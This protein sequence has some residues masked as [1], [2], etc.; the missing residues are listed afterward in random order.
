MGQLRIAIKST[1][2]LASSVNE[3]KRKEEEATGLFEAFARTAK[4]PPSFIT[5]ARRLIRTLEVSEL[6][7]VSKPKDP[8]RTH[9]T[10][11][12]R[13]HLCSDI[14]MI[15]KRVSKL[16]TAPFAFSAAETQEALIHPTTV[17]AS[18]DAP[19]SSKNAASLAHL[20]PED[21]V[22]ELELEL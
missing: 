21:G 3:T 7:E 5:S 9:T 13:L 1:E 10:T 2:G 16:A 19:S 12:L 17:S 8:A 22:Q 14:L 15:S 4:C 20:A 11:T 18:I 6:L